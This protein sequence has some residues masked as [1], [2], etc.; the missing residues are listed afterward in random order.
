[1]YSLRTDVVGIQMSQPHRTFI[2]ILHVSIVRR[3]NFRIIRA[4]LILCFIEPA[5][6]SQ[7]YGPIEYEE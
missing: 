6:H 2:N 3:D 1:M 4:C 5:M 7:F